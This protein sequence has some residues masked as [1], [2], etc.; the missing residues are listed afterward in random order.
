MRRWIIFSAI[1]AGV[2]GASSRPT[3]TS[4]TR[5]AAI[6]PTTAPSTF[7]R[8]S[9]TRWITAL[10]F[11]R[12]RCRVKIVM[13]GRVA[14]EPLPRANESRAQFVLEP[15]GYGGVTREAGT[16]RNARRGQDDAGV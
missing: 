16:D 9:L 11:L 8:A 3:A 1:A 5:P 15:F 12:P 13:R 6:S 10:I 14:S 2:P 4:A 7:T